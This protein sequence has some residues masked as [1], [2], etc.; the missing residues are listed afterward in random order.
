MAP[1]N[2]QLLMILIMLIFIFGFG[3][4][5]QRTF[6]NVKTLSAAS[7]NMVGVE[8]A[9]SFN[10]VPAKITGVSAEIYDGNVVLSWNPIM[11]SRLNG[12]RIYRGESSRAQFII[13]GSTQAVFK[14]SSVA[15]NSIYYYR[16]AAINDLGEGPLSAPIRVNVRQR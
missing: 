12:Y 11:R 2:R 8:T 1:T 10:T 15:S 5:A 4:I 16:I 9:L 3:Y 13:G 7:L 14:D 6:N